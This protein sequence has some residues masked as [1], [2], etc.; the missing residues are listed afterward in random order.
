VAVV[1]VV[2]TLL[3]LMQLLTWVAVAVVLKAPEVIYLLVV[4]EA[5][6]LL[7]FLILTEVDYNYTNQLQ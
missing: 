6:V 1:M 7:L 3:V 2:E 5:P 4:L